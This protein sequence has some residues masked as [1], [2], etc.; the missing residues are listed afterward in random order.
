MVPMLEIAAYATTEA[1]IIIIIG[2]SM[3][4]YPAA[5]LVGYAPSGI[6]IYYVDPNPTINYELA[7]SGNLKV[8]SE[9]ATTGVR[10]V[11]NE[12]LK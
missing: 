7:N 10:K 1:D 3:Q 4:V 12:L 5:G 8:I 11:V 9:K 6:P 2:T